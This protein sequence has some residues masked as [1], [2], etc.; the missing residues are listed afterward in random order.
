[1]KSGQ[2]EQQGGPIMATLLSRAAVLVALGA[3]LLLG[4]GCAARSGGGTS[5]SRDR[6]VVYPDELSGDVG[7]NLHDA[8]Q[9]LRPEWFTRRGA[10][11]M[12]AANEGDVV[13]YRD[14]ARM[15][16]PGTLRDVLAEMVL[17]VRFMS[18]ID[19]QTRYGL[20]HQHGAII[21]TTRNR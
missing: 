15:G 10:T 5:V 6:T 11:T 20:G 8:L 4:A 3:A 21:V 12:N 7:R 19:A 14:G 17:S 13:V 2:R 9:R 16:G 1:M 18:A